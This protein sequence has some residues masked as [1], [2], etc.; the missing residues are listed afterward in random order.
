[1]DAQSTLQINI[2]EKDKTMNMIGKFEKTSGIPS[3]EWKFDNEN[4]K[5][6]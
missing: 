3:V 2:G 1:M 5:S 6:I 4:K